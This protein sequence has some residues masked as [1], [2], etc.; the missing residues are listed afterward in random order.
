[1]KSQSKMENTKSNVGEYGP[2]TKMK[3]GSGTMGE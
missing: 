2:P 3:E 1:M